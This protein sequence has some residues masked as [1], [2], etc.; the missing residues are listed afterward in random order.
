MEKPALAVK[1]FIVKKGKLL[2]LKRSDKDIHHP[3]K[4]ELPGGRLEEGEDPILGLK[5]E[6]KEEIG[7]EVEPILPFNVQHFSRDDGQIITMIIYAC[8]VIGGKET[9]SEEHSAFEWISLKK[10]KEKLTR[11][12]HKEVDIFEKLKIEK[13]LL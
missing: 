8:K 13:L 5:R 11:F 6:V 12:F 2:I 9:L 3:S 1:A 4:W 10:S 7:L